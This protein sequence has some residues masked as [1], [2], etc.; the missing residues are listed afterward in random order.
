MDDIITI[1]IRENNRYFAEGLKYSLI[2]YFKNKKINVFFVEQI[3]PGIGI[4]LIFESL[5]CGGRF[6]ICHHNS[7]LGYPSPRF[8]SIRD[9]KKSL[10]LKNPWCSNEMGILYRQQE[11]TEFADTLT[12]VWEKSAPCTGLFLRCNCRV[13]TRREIQVMHCLKRGMHHSQIATELGLSTKTISV[14]KQSVIK[15][16]HLKGKTELMYWLL[17][18]GLN[19]WECSSNRG[20]YTRPSRGKTGVLNVVAGKV[21]TTDST[22]TVVVGDSGIRRRK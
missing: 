11:F 6:L 3:T 8:F 18:G 4:D 22:V 14:Y 9:N 5:Y 16:L 2:D 21:V 15:K 12:Q 7:V 19:N 20:N 13:L 17:S 1:L 10:Q